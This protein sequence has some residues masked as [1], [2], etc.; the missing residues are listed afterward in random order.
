[1]KRFY[2]PSQFI[3]FFCH[4]LGHEYSLHIASSLSRRRGAFVYKKQNPSKTIHQI[5]MPPQKSRESVF[6][7]TIHRSLMGLLPT[8]V[9]C[10]S[11]NTAHA[12]PP[13]YR[14]E[15]SVPQNLP[16]CNREADLIGMV[17]PMLA[18]PVLDPPAT[19]VLVVKIAKTKNNYLV[20][21][22]VNDLDG[23]KLDE[24]R[25]DFPADMSCYEVLYRAALRVTVQMNKGV[26]AAKPAQT[27]PPPPSPAPP[28]CS[29][30]ELPRAPA[31][32]KLRHWFV[33]AGMRLDMGVAPDELIGGHLIVGWRRSP[34]W[35]LEAH[36]RATLSN[37]TRPLGPTVV[38]V[39]SVGSLAFVP[40]YRIEPFGFCGEFV[41]GNIWFSFLNLRHPQL[42][43]A[44][45]WGAGIR[46]F[47]EQP[48]SE[49]LSV[50]MDV[51]LFVPFLPAQIA[52]DSKR[53]RW[54]TSIVSGSASVSL[55]AWF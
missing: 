14:V 50:R 27:P 45:F 46:G 16:E 20:D 4:L 5:D 22:L 53:E 33:G 8:L 47:L 28:P 35:S 25:T 40:C 9:W 55:F 13:H 1:M 37:D 48:L 29:P 17:L 49:R 41:M 31:P 30:C 26:R 7:R 24:E 51:D 15:L 54:E 38:R 52:H 18:G 36:G 2:I 6:R 10:L 44:L 11:P 34:R 43:T 12:E 23:N 42:D 3:H 32:K 39:H 21:V 19:R